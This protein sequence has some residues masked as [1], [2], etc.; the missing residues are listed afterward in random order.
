MDHDKDAQKDEQHHPRRPAN[1]HKLS[2]PEYN[3]NEESSQWLYKW[4]KFF[5]AQNT[6]E[7]EQMHLAAFHLQGDALTWFIK[8]EQE[9]EHP[10]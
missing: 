3:G 1:H 8:W 6:K 5:D 4:N 2:F 7:D 9:I 10:N